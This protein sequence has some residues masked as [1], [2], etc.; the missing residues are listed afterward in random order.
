MLG[1]SMGVYTKLQLRKRLDCSS[2][3]VLKLSAVDKSQVP[4]VLSIRITE[5]S[6][7]SSGERKKGGGIVLVCFV[8]FRF[9][10]RPLSSQTSR[11]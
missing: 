8:L 6:L 4:P 10:G 11:C 2:T 9:G 3:L 5:R 7:A 1:R